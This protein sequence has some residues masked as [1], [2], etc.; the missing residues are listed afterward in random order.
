MN[1]YIIFFEEV[2][3]V[4]YK[5]QLSLSRK[6]A[7]GQS[8]FC[9]FAQEIVIKHPRGLKCNDE[10]ACLYRYRE[11]DQR[12]WRN[13]KNYKRCIKLMKCADKYFSHPQR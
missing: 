4:F 11:G 7:P 5:V 9:H 13:H 12:I 1:V 6:K 10:G 2:S 8:E 3:E